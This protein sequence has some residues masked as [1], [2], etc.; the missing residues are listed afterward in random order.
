MRTSVAGPSGGVL[1]FFDPGRTDGGGAIAPLPK[2]SIVLLGD[3]R[4]PRRL[5]PWRLPS[6]VTSRAPTGEPT[7]HSLSSLPRS[8]T[9][10]DHTPLATTRDAPQS[11]KYQLKLS[12]RDCLFAPRD[13]NRKLEF[14]EQTQF[15]PRKQ[16]IFASKTKPFSTRNS[17]NRWPGDQSSSGPIAQLLSYLGGLWK[18]SL[19][20]GGRT[21]GRF[22]LAHHKR[23]RRQ[24]E[25]DICNQ[26]EVIDEGQ[27]RRLF[28]HLLVNHPQ[29]GRTPMARN[30]VELPGRCRIGVL[31]NAEAE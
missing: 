21:A 14:T 29:E 13:G 8:S 27:H 7:G 24:E 9:P 23:Q 20:G 25:E 10:H 28:L 5:V 11:P 30:S 17:P 4:P 6:A 22:L 31:P 2:R 3:T 18:A 16:T 19:V 26:P 15:L 1:S 12:E